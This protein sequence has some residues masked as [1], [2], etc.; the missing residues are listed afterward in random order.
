MKIGQDLIIQGNYLSFQVCNYDETAL[1]WD[2]QS[3]LK[4]QIEQ[5]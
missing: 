1:T 5:S 2:I 3:A 4:M